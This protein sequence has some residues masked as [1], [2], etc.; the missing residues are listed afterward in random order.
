M[1]D[2]ALAKIHG[3]TKQAVNRAR[4]KHARGQLPAKIPSARRRVLDDALDEML[5]IMGHYDP[6]SSDQ[7]AYNEGLRD[8]ANAIRGWTLKQQVAHPLDCPNA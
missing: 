6:A 5:G 4:A 7:L 3:V 1:T 2:M 8:M